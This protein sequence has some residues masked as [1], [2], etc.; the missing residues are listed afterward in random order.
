LVLRRFNTVNDRLL[1]GGWRFCKR[2]KEAPG[3]IEH[4][5]ASHHSCVI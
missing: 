1:H 4:V 2:F 3:F 5:T